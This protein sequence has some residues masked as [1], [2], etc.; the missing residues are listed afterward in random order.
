MNASTT[1]AVCPYCER[2]ITGDAPHITCDTCGAC[3]HEACWVAR[4][5]CATP[6]CA[7]QPIPLVTD[8]PI[9][10]LPTVA[11]PVEPEKPRRKSS[12]VVAGAAIIFAGMLL[13]RVLG[14]IREN[15]MFGTFG[16]SNTAGAYNLAFVFPDLFYNLLAGGAMSAAFI[17]VFTS[18]LSKDE[19]HKAHEVGSSVSTLLLLA[20]TVCVIICIIFAPQVIGALQW[21]QPP[22]KRLDPAS[23]ALTVSLTRIM[24]FMLIFTA[25]SGHLTGILQSFKHF[26]TPV[27]VW[28]VYNVAIILGIGVFSKLAIFG[29]SPT[30]PSIHGVAYSV[31]FGAFL[32]A[33]IQF[34]VAIKYGFRFTWKL[35]LKHEGVRRV[36]KLF[37]PVMISLAL[38]QINLMLLPLIIGTHFGLPAVTDIRA[39]NRLVLLPLGLFAIAISTAAFPKLAQLMAQGEKSAFRSTLVQS[40]KMILL[41]SVPS[42]MILF[43]LA[44][45]ITYLLWGGG[46]FGATG[47]Q[48]S[49][50]VLIFFAWGL[51]GLG[52]A[53]ILNRAFYSMHDTLTPTVVGVAMVAASILLSL[54]FATH[55]SLG[56]DYA[57]V[58]LATT[59]TTTAS[60]LVLL[61][62]LR[63]RLGG[64]NGWSL[65]ITTG[66]IFL[67]AT[68]MGIVMYVVAKGLAPT[69]GHATLGPVFRWPAPPVPHERDITTIA[70]IHVPRL[71]LLAQVGASLLAGGAVYA[72]VL[73]VLKVDELKMIVARLTGRFHR[74]AAG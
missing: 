45:P 14:L 44:E 71:L 38:S 37:L 60:T 61:E 26:L 59:V 34:P 66:K 27:V 10:D 72:G 69:F 46:K 33:A 62:L 47:V 50:F 63:R 13:S 40:I 70:A 22:D 68:A 41:L 58:A 5:G 25:Q 52:L 39:A 57:S 18:Y 35:D 11:V 53:Q 17:P 2:P 21:L 28:L 8:D 48:A 19:D 32:L 65:L 6:A 36:L 54:Y 3:S 31:V 12:S 29:G 67:G 43:V 20:M 55:N 16:D 7:G 24:C 73:W 9:Q 56:M 15:M 51:L 30:N 4:G 49:A 74:P 42:A 23:I 1:D 64:I